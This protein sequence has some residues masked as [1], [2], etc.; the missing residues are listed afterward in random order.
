[1]PEIVVDKEAFY[2]RM[3]K[4]YSAWRVNFIVDEL[5]TACFHENRQ[6]NSEFS[7]SFRQIRMRHC[8]L[9]GTEFVGFNNLI[10]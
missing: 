8:V 4:V 10:G 9:C 6:T 7:R 3:K 1:M 2:R 5:L